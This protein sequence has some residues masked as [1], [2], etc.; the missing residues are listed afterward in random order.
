MVWLLTGTRLRLCGGG[1]WFWFGLVWFGLVDNGSP[2]GL[3]WF[4][5]VVIGSPIRTI[6]FLLVGG[7]SDVV[8]MVSITG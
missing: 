1:W 5:L 3:V 2:I 7:T 6:Q 4:G 8:G